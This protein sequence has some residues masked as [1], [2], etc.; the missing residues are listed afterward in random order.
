MLTCRHWYQLSY[1]LLFQTIFVSDPADIP[2]VCI[3]LD[4]SEGLGW[5][6]QR[7]HVV[8]WYE[9]RGLSLSYLSA[10]LV[11]IVQQCQNLTLF[12]VEWSLSTTF[13]D[14]AGSL[15]M[16]A[17]RT[18]RSFNVNITPDHLSRFIWA[19]DCLPELFSVHVEIAS[20]KD[21]E[22][23]EITPRLGA[24]S[25]LSLSLPH[26]QQFSIRGQSQALVDQAC[27]WSLPALSA[28]TIDFGLYTADMPDILA[29][30]AAHG[31]TLLFLDLNTIPSVDVSAVLA[32]CPFIASFAFNAD[33]RLAFHDADPAGS[34]PFV[35]MPHPHL[36]HIGLHQLLHAFLPPRGDAAR[37]AV[38][39]VQRTN[40][41][42][43]AQLTRRNFPQLT[44]VRLLSRPLLAGLERNDG[45]SEEGMARWERWDAQCRLAGVRL[46]DCTGAMFGDLPEDEDSLD[47]FGEY[48][49]DAEEVLEQRAQEREAEKPDGLMPS[50]LSEL[51][52]LIEE[53]RQLDVRDP[54]DG[55]FAAMAA[56]ADRPSATAPWIAGT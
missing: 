25:N 16:F 9:P 32:R 12:T 27:G 13:P 46:E 33:W 10:M 30:L 22:P 11:S 39:A 28:L 51:R 56:S 2:A 15:S 42:T 37:T 54:L 44:L 49:S 29:F 4:R 26:L 34:A 5:Y 35:H 47:A 7:I 43:F 6:V 38:A 3:A 17:S 55:M 36:R 24:A 19:L 20:A 18:L 50:N 45:P 40:D 1:Y 52:G 14:V 21:T 48:D 8:R 31:Q 53:I 23:L 41:A